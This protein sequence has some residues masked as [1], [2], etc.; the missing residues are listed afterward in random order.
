MGSISSQITS[1]TIVCS[2]VY[3]D[4]DQRKHQSSASLA[5]VWGI[6]RGPVNS[7]HKWPVT[8]KMFPFD[9]MMSTHF[10]Y[11]RFCAPSNHLLIADN[12]KPLTVEICWRVT[13][14][15]YIRSKT[16]IKRSLNFVVF[17]DGVFH[18]REDKH[19][20]VK[21]VPGK[22]W[23]LCVFGKT[24]PV[25]LYRFYYIYTFSLCHFQHWDGTGS[26]NPSS[27]KVRTYSSCT[28]NTIV[29]DDLV[30]QR[31]RASAAMVL[32]CHRRIFQIQHQ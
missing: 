29:A 21:T 22:W 30:T 27:S 28:V 10:R 24:F 17:Q 4:A 8:Q 12:M 1:L 13:P 16:C 23:N 14:R 15:I 18:D 9:V 26:W 11:R 19:D 5:F 32:T 6:Q 3:S 20:F 25:S 2:T 31:A 7:P